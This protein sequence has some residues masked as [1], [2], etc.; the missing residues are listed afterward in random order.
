MAHYNPMLEKLQQ[1]IQDF[2]KDAEL[3]IEKVAFWQNLITLSFVVFNII[4]FITLEVLIGKKE[5]LISELPNVVINFV[6]T[7]VLLLASFPLAS[8]YAKQKIKSLQLT[9]EAIE[10]KMNYAGKWKYH[11]TF[12]VQSPSDGSTEY[13]RFYENMKDYEEVGESEWSQSVFDLKIDFGVSQVP[14]GKPHVKW[15]SDPVFYDDYEVRWSFSGKIWWA[16]AVDYANE[17]SGIESYTVTS[18]DENKRPTRLDG[19]LKG[20]VLIGKKFYVVDAVSW[21]E[22][23]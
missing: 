15:H 13:D 14:E 21:F 9:E 4:V 22:R 6:F 20:I 10:P 19:H 17:F 12:R 18:R 8:K 7:L 11:T 23:V 1:Q 2:N 3:R 16:D 5:P